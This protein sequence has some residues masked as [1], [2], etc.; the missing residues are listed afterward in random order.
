M[1]ACFPFSQGRNS[2]LIFRNIFD[3]IELNKGGIK[4]L[5]ND[6]EYELGKRSSV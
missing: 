4:R 6:E 5:K 1:T 3:A 2:V